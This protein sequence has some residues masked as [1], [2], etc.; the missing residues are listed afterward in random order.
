VQAAAV[1]NAPVDAGPPP[2]ER[3]GPGAALTAWVVTGIIALTGLTVYGQVS[4]GTSTGFLVL[5]VSVGVASCALVPVLLRWPVAGALALS[6]LAALSAAATPA[7]TAAVLYVAQRRRFTVAVGVAV[8]GITAHAIRGVWRPITGLPYGWYFVL[9][10]VS[11]AA[12]VGW[13]ALTQARHALIDSLRERAERAEVERDRRVAEARA[14]ERTRIARE[15]HDV[16]AHRLSLLATYSGAMEYRPDSSPE[17]LSRAAAVIRAGAHQALDELRQV[18]TLLREDEP[19]SDGRSLPRPQPG[20]EDL[21]HLVDESR[22]AGTSVQYVDHLGDPAGVPPGLGRTVFRVVQEGL[23]NA[24]KHAAGQ[25]VE[26]VLEG[27]PGQWLSIEITNP[28]PGDGVAVPA[29]P[30]TGTGLIGLT[31]RVDLAGGRLSRETTAAG[32][33][34]LSVWLPWPA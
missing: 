15:M 23:T 3:S 20:L 31:E 34:R 18:I 7:A 22:A 14:S 5:D 16:L 32:G 28:P 21:P 19:E 33:F 25:P 30:G 13:G 8:A 27:Q 6:V 1:N 29:A 24:R 2:D 4:S 10:V 12:L 11:Y 17:Q 26:V 9:V